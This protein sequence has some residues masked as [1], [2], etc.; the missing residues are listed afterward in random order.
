MR[1]DNPLILFSM[2]VISVFCIRLLMSPCSRGRAR[3]NMVTLAQLQP[4]PTVQ[5]VVALLLWLASIDVAVELVAHFAIEVLRPFYNM[6][7]VA[8]VVASALTGLLWVLST[9]SV[10]FFQPDR[11]RNLAADAERLEISTEE[12]VMRT[13][14]SGLPQLKVEVD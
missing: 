2:A 10:S 6:S 12:V 1:S 14:D 4:R 11:D 3:G 8:A 13:L 9:R 7:T 5:I